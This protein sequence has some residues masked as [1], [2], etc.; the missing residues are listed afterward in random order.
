MS[1]DIKIG[2][3]KLKINVGPSFLL[4]PLK[5]QDCA[6]SESPRP[7]GAQKILSNLLRS[8]CPTHRCLGIQTLKIPKKGK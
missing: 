3:Q 2:T 5:D 4:V 7:S 1:R 8:A 6:L